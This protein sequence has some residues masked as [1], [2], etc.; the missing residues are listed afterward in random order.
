[1]TIA[2]P[3]ASAWPEAARLA[4]LRQYDILD[5]PA[6]P[7][8]DALTNLAARICWTPM[9]DFGLIDRNLVWFKSQVGLGVSEIP[10]DL[11]FCERTIQIGDL[12]VV[13]DAA[14]DPVFRESPLVVG[15]PK[16]RFYAGVPVRCGDGLPI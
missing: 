1:M 6:D 5:T 10:R 12:C 16:A 11:A 9:A 15:P 8:F 2:R 14:L 7:T 13:Q 4:A 3:Q